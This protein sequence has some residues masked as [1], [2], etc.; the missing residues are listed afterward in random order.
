MPSAG[1]ERTS[2][3]YPRYH[4]GQLSDFPQ[5]RA[6]VSIR[7]IYG[8]LRKPSEIRRRFDSGGWL[9]HIRVGFH[10]V[11]SLT[12]H[13]GVAFLSPAPSGEADRSAITQRTQNL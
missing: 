10:L 6:S 2:H 9:V 12:A 5:P 1:C 7:E 11:A 4:V 13:S 8:L 3:S